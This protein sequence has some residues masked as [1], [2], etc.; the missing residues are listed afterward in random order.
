MNTGKTTESGSSGWSARKRLD[1]LLLLAIVSVLGLGLLLWYVVANRQGDSEAEMCRRCG[2]T[3]L[4]SRGRVKGSRSVAY[5]YRSPTYNQC[6][7]DWQIGW[8]ASY[9]PPIPTGVVIL[10]RQDG[11]YGAFVMRRQIPSPER[12]EYAWW[13]C[14]DGASDFR[15]SQNLV[16]SEGEAF[17]NG[18]M[19]APIRFGPFSVGWSSSEPGAGF[20]Y[21]RHVPC[22]DVASTDLHF[23]VT[24]E[25]SIENIDASDPKWD[26]RAF[27]APEANEGRLRD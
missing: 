10:V 5:V 7:H 20:L 18:R 14:A 17:V 26:Y 4:I 15:A 24:T 22:E 27:W 11:R 12:V 13:L 16:T 3:R 6:S 8:L 23:C 1:R 2:S 9:Q 19:L 21:Y 25:H